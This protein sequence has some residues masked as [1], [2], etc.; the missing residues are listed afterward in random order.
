MYVEICG[1]YH[2]S[3]RISLYVYIV[4][5]AFDHWRPQQLLLGLATRCPQDTGRGYFDSYANGFGAK[6]LFL[7]QV[8]LI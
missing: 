1:V 4:I 6:L 7:R 2:L 5:V 3:W 8:N